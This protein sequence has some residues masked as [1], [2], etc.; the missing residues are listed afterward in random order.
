MKGTR[1]RRKRRFFKRQA[2]IFDEVLKHVGRH[3]EFYASQ[4]VELADGL[5]LATIYVHLAAMESKGFFKSYQEPPDP[6]RPGMRRRLYRVT[7][8]GVQAYRAYCD[9]LAV[10]G[11]HRFSRHEAAT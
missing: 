3:R 9:G 10:E 8:E 2:H 6:R 1:M 7:E 4:L 11:G 5:S